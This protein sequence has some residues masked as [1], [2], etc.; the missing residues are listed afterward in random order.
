[1]DGGDR[2]KNQNIFLAATEQR[3]WAVV[4]GL[5]VHHLLENPGLGLNALFSHFG[6]EIVPHPIER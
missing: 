5:N 3:D 6:C 2:V 1:M 4:D